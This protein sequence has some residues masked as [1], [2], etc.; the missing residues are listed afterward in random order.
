MAPSGVQKRVRLRKL[1]SGVRHQFPQPDPFC[2]FRPIG[3]GRPC[4]ARETNRRICG[5]KDE[6]KFENSLERLLIEATDSP[7]ARPQFYRELMHSSVLTCP[8][9]DLEES[10]DPKRETTLKLT[11]ITVKEIQYVPFYSAE[12]F[13][14][15]G[16]RYLSL[17]AR[18][19]F[20]ITKGSH[21]VLNAGDKFVKTFSP[22]EVERLL[23]GH[24]LEVEKEF[25]I[26]TSARLSIGKPKEIPPHLLEQLS[27]FFAAEDAVLRAWLAWYH[28]PEN[29]SRPG[30]LLA[31][32]TT[33]SVDFRVLA[34]MVTL[35][36]KEVGTGGRH[37]CDIAQYTGH[38][39]TSYFRFE[40]PFYSKPALRRMWATVSGR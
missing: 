23:S 28:Q 26:K 37:Y 5:V 29:E 21:L 34:G 15:R 16:V 4:Q 3:P 20:E 40:T 39:L 35:V 27:K 38:D 9:G 30:Y 10:D 12:K 7:A 1:I 11:V 14:P 18:Q 19:F 33:R 32:E 6:P 24:L 2:S 13:L 8:H 36:I 22:A 31:I 17:P 25:Q